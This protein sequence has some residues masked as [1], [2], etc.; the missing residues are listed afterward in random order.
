M[1]NITYCTVLVVAE[2]NLSHKMQRIRVAVCPTISLEDQVEQRSL[3]QRLHLRLRRDHID[4]SAAHQTFCFRYH[5]H[6][7]GVLRGSNQK[8][9]AMSRLLALP[10][11]LL[12]QVAKFAILGGN[13]D[14][15]NPLVLKQRQCVWHP[16][17]PFD[18]WPDLDIALLAT[19]KHIN[20]ICQPIMYDCVVFRIFHSVPTFVLANL[21]GYLRRLGSAAQKLQRLQLVM[22]LSTFRYVD[23]SHGLE[24]LSSILIGLLPSLEVIQVSMQVSV[25]A[26]QLPHNF[27]LLPLYDRPWSLSPYVYGAVTA[28]ILA[29]PSRTRIDFHPEIGRQLHQHRI[30]LP[31]E[32]LEDVV[33][34]LRCRLL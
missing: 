20:R 19:C 26:L 17:L 23:V 11:E 21:P 8:R 16:P 1:C 30:V 9:I 14:T 15:K 32:L 7:A 3:R 4:R 28:L 34:K 22:V 33:Y 29:M 2:L 27:T 5:D 25:S 10:D 13:Y 31:S 6:S 12:E 18:A 24:G